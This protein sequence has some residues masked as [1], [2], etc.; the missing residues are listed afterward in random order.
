MIWR[1][2]RR[3]VRF[4]RRP[5]VMGIVNINDDSFSG[6]GTLDVDEA[7][8]IAKGQAAAGADVIDVGAESART[9]RDAVSVAEEVRRFSEFLKRWPDEV[10]ELSPRDEAQLWPPVLSANTWRPEVVEAVLPL[11]VELVNDMGG[12]PDDRNARLCAAA[13]ASLLIMH[14]VGPPKVPQLDRRWPDVMAA[15]EAFFE[16]TIARAEAAGLERERL[17][18]DPGIDFA[19]QREDNLIVYRELERLARFGRPL[20][21]PVSRKTVIGEV[22]DLPEPADRDAGTMACIAAAVRRG[23]AMLRVHEVEGTWQVVKVLEG[24]RSGA[25]QAP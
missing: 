20:M 10:A 11:G 1:L 15:M 19:K 6:D 22:L 16:E 14:T 21:V 13:G 9:N 12:L 23:A 7:L 4:P 17:V 5:L 3:E 18:L 2:P 24:V 8:R 25:F